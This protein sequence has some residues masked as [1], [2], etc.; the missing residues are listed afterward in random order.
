MVL[1]LRG[2]GDPEAVARYLESNKTNTAKKTEKKVPEVSEM[3]VAAGGF[4]NQTIVR[5][6]VRPEKWDT[7]N[8]VMFNLQLLNASAFE[9][10]LGIKAPS[11]PVTPA[12][13]KEHGF[14]FF[15]LYEEK[16][17]I[18]GEFA[19]IKSVAQLDQKRGIKRN[20]DDEKL[21]AFPTVELNA[22]DLP[23]TFIPVSQ[24]EDALK[25]FNVASEI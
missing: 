23:S 20:R 21:I 10:L 25:V 13:Y 24:M 8:T 17:G 18:S 9:R 19:G 16:S 11:T 6:P 7:K 4:I 14:P 15:K 12:V 5:D 22:A 1:R 2:G 3:A